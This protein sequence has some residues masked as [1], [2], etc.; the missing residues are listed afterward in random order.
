MA[1]HL[2]PHRNEESVADKLGM[3]SAISMHGEA[4]RQVYPPSDLGIVGS[5]SCQWR[6]VLRSRLSIIDEKDARS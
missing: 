1:G 4:A 6:Q 3:G 2:I 5:L